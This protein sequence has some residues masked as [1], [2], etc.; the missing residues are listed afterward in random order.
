MGIFEEYLLMK[1]TTTPSRVKD[2]YFSL[3]LLPTTE[4]Q[5]RRSV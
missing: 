4:D 5:L 3:G 1:S 2:L